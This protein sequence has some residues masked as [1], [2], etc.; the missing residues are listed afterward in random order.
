RFAA[1]RQRP[2]LV[3]E[4]RVEEAYLHCAK[5][6][7]RS[8]LWQPADWPARDLLPSRNQMLHAQ[9]GMAEAPE[10]AAAMA[11]RYRQ[12]RAEEPTPAR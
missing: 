11:A 8:Q 10:P 1:E 4:V 5:A 12:Q 7:M 3:I 9:L 2:K 6:F